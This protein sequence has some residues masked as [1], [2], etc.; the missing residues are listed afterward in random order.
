[1]HPTTTIPSALRVVIRVSGFANN[2]PDERPTLASQGL[3]KNL[4]HQGR[5]LGALSEEFE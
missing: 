1:M 3:D 2:S 5:V 4:A